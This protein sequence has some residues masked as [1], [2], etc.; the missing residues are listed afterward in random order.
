MLSFLFVVVVAAVVV[1]MVVVVVVMVVV[2]KVNLRMCNIIFSLLCFRFS[3]MMKHLGMLTKFPELMN[4]GR[5]FHTSS[6]CG[7]II[8]LTRLRVVD[9]SDIGKQAMAEGKPPKCIHIYNKK[10]VGTIGM[11]CQIRY[12]IMF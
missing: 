11:Y 3:A 8:K 2:S 12:E 5:T 4:V 1:V 10:G 9:N 7:H 6:V